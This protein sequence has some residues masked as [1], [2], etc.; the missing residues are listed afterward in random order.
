MRSPLSWGILAA[1]LGFLLVLVPAP[2]QTPPPAFRSVVFEPDVRLGG[3]RTRG[4]ATHQSEPTIVLNPA[5][6]DNMVAGFIDYQRTGSRG[7]HVNFLATFDGGRSWTADV[8]APLFDSRTL[9]GDP[10][11]AGFLDGGFL[12]AYLEYRGGGSSLS[13]VDVVVSRSDDGGRTFGALAL[14]ADGTASTSYDKPYLTVDAGP[15]SPFRGTAYLAV[16]DFLRGMTV[17]V[18]RDGGAQWTG[19]TLLAPAGTLL[20][21]A[22]VPVVAPDGTVYVFYIEYGFGTQPY[23]YSIRY[24]ASGDG[25]QTWGAPVIALA[26]LPT[27]GEFRLKNADPKFGGTL[28]AGLLVTSF[29]TAAITPAGD[30]FVAWVDFPDGFCP[31]TRSSSSPCVNADVRL[32]VSRDRGV[33]WSAPVRVHDDATANDQFFPWLAAHP[34]GLVSIIWLDRRNDPDNINFDAYY[35]N[36]YDGQTFLPNVRVSTATSLLGS[37]GWI[38]DYQGIAATAGGVFPIWNDARTGTPAAF[39]ARGTLLP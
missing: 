9:S 21:H 11:F 30:I 1:G 37:L 24:A 22:P 38:G 7:G 34:D 16:P 28:G 27:P 8:R 15:A 17:F 5:N 29:P 12:Y 35:T 3:A 32:T 20:Q 26:G 31:D 25:G 6:P 2:A 23:T 36:T 13:A 19:P 33:T 4:P 18:S 10:S 39:F 14:A